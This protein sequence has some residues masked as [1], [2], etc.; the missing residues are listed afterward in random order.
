MDGGHIMHLSYR[1]ALLLAL[2]TMGCAG[3]VQVTRT[4]TPQ[5]AVQAQ[6]ETPLHPV[7]IVRPGGR[8]QLPSDA[9]VEPGRVVFPHA[10]LYVH[11]LAP[12]D[13]I[14]QDS[15]GR[16]TGV[17][18]GST[19]PVVMRFV[20]GTAQSPSG[21]DEVR[22]VREDG[23][24]ALALQPGDAIEM[25]GTFQPDEALPGGGRVESTR[26]T[27]MLVGGIVVLTLAYAP[28]VYV[29]VNSV[30]PEDRVLAVPAA[31]PWID[32]ANRP[33][34]VPPQLPAGV[35]LP[36]DPC[37]AETAARAA[38]VASG[39]LQD[40]G[41]VFTLIGL[42]THSQIVSGTSRGVSEEKPKPH[43]GIVP[44]GTGA[45]AVGVF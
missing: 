36:V 15:Q 21:S 1:S 37:I 3:P 6:S 20:P 14:E 16:I 11:K 42:P 7:A 30:R 29:G 25:T 24:G 35:H 27:G 38:L 22:G 39:A 9:R 8:V 4:Y 32:L 40:L 23:S 10:Q 2:V 18:S 28:T 44:T 34:C 12:G 5:A 26:S 45:A 17:R 13:V 43:I 41:L 31:G 19:P 33:A